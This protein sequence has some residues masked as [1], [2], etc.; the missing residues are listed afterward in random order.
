MLWQTKSS[1]DQVKVPVKNNPMVF[2]IKAVIF[3]A[4]ELV[5]VFLAAYLSLKPLDNLLQSG[6][7]IGALAILFSFYGL[8]ALVFPGWAIVLRMVLVSLVMVVPF[9]DRVP[10]S[11]LS[12]VWLVLLAVLITGAFRA[13]N[14][15]DNRIQFSAWGS[16]ASSRGSA[17]FCLSLILTL[18]LG[19]PFLSFGSAAFSEQMIDWLIKPSEK[20]FQQF[21][22]GISLE[23]TANDLFNQLAEKQTSSA[24]LSGGMPTIPSIDLSSFG[25]DLSA[26]Q[27][28]LIQG[29]ESQARSEFIKRMSAITGLKISGKEKVSD[30]LYRYLEEQYQGLS[31]GTRN[32]L[33]KGIFLL[34]FLSIMGLV[35]MVGFVW[36]F[37]ELLVFGLLKSMRLIRI[38]RITVEKEVLSL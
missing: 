10:K 36:S 12:I 4:L 35:N 8:G 27:D 22:P 38:T 9:A 24:G 13:K 28:Q 25:L 31:A 32:I 11:E 15:A 2:P 7:L 18:C 1:P 17:I 21:I 3:V 30:L 37:I 5:L 33:G 16:L 29:W 23:M 14:Q 6:L 34:L 19:A 26:Y 20:I